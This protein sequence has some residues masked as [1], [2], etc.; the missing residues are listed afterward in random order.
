M[1]WTVRKNTLLAWGVIAILAVVCVCGFST[2]QAPA[3][4]MLNQTPRK[5]PVY[6]VETQEKKVALTFDAA[7]GADKT[8]QI[9]DILAENQ[10]Q[11]T[12]FLVG[13]WV[14]ENPELVKAIAQSGCDIGNHSQ[15]HLKMSTLSEA[16]IDKEI[17]SVNEAVEQLTGQKP[18][19]FRAPFGDY[20]NRLIGA[21][22]DMG[23]IPIQWDVDSLDWKGLD[24][25]QILGRV[26]KSVKGGSIVLCHNNSDHIV[27][28]LPL[29]IANLINQGYQIVPLHELVYDTPYYVDSNGE[30]HKQG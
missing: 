7:W 10:V 1:F 6:R 18:K 24:A 25:T 28:A 26:T 27:D 12:F 29:L 17:R 22:E 30:Q 21:V 11:A 16:D 5:I 14:E 9:L 3:A 2:T 15:N 13:F 8:Q 23:M 4:V 19:Y 20:N